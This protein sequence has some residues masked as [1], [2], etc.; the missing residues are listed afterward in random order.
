M[1]RNKSN[2]PIPMMIPSNFHA[3]WAKCLNHL[4]R[5][6]ENWGIPQ[7]MATSMRNDGLNVSFLRVFWVFPIS[8]RETQLVSGVLHWPPQDAEPDD[9]AR[10]FGESVEKSFSFAFPRWYILGTLGMQIL[11]W[12]HVYSTQLKNFPVGYQPW[13]DSPG[14]QDHPG[15]HRLVIW[16]ETPAQF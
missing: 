12:K 6:A 14:Q 11:S 2:F 13:F 3:V 15:N 16:G 4:E 8:F 1:F 5:F 7:L 10:Q 9:A